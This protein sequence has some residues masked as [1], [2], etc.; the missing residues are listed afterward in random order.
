[1]KSTAEKAQDPETQRE[2]QDLGYGAWS[3]ADL[4]NILATSLLPWDGSLQV[5]DN[6]GKKRKGLSN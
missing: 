2:H 1:M 6:E 3:W 4:K 5:K